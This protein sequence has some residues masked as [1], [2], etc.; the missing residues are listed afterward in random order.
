MN[1]YEMTQA[2][3]ELYE[4]LQN[5]EIDEQTL[6]D[7]LES[8]EADKKLESYVYVL[9]SLAAELVM[10]EDEK[11]RITNKISVLNNRMDRMKNAIIEFMQSAGMKKTKAGTFDLSLRYFDS[12]NIVDEKL[13]AD[14]YLVAQ[15]PKIDKTAIKKAIVE[16][17][18]V[19]GVEIV[20]RPSVIAR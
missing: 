1:L 3:K 19:K 6:R 16:G 5:E 20:S 14:E 13:I 15:P 17:Q 2:A 18:I 10:F 4:M 7:T 11:K 12:V 8:I 9:K